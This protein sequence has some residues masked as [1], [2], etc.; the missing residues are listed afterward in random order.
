V[1]V[2]IPLA[3]RGTRMRPHTHSKPKPLLLVAGKPGINYILDELKK[4]DVTEIIFITGHLKEEIE[5]YIKTN[6]SDFKTT[7]IEQK[8]KDGTAGA[9]KLAKDHVNEPC[10]IIFV[11][12]VFDADLSI[13]KNLKEDEAGVIWTKEVEDYQRFGVCLLNDKGYLTKIVEKPNEPIS[14]LANIGLYYVKDYKL[15]FEGIEHIYKED[16]KLKG[17]YFLTDA[18]AYMVEKGANILCPTVD[19]WYDFGKPETLLESNRELLKKGNTNTINTDNSVIIPPVFI[20]EG[21]KIKNSVIGPYVTIDKDVTVEESIISDSIISYG[22]SIK[23]M[24]LKE[25]LVGE[26]TQITETHRTLNIGDH[27][28]VEFSKK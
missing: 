24:M 28:K 12:T 4:L 25:S 3:G 11:D 15:M 14:K 18:F 23:G 26:E 2:I 8:V 17:E 21:A 9:I 1:K 13:V 20:A 5:N 16:K 6:Y 7:F 10:M 22:S 27:S 19:G